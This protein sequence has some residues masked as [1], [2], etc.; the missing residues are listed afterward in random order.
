MAKK[1]KSKAPGIEA[2]KNVSIR[3]LTMAAIKPFAAAA[4]E[5][6]NKAFK[7]WEQKEYKPPAYY[8][9]KKSGGL[10]S[11]KGK[12]TLNQQKKELARAIRFLTDPT[13][14]VKGWEKEK[15]SQT[16]I[17]NAKV[18]EAERENELKT[19]DFDRF[20]EAF[21][22]AV[23]LEP[24][25]ATERYKYL[26]VDALIEELDDKT[27]SVDELAVAMKEKFPEIYKNKIMEDE[28]NSSDEY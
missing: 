2:L 20:Y 18:K 22:K 15:K 6:A 16:G 3:T 23:E 5:L 14:T 24:S 27:K 26:V 13:R 10:I 19:E 11:F 4:R 21:D 8:G 28:K 9:M 17:I 1:K 7:K 12:K 25:I